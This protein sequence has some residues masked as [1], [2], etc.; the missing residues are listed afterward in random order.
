MSIESDRIVNHLREHATHP[1]RTAELGRALEVK[2]AERR[3]FRRVLRQ[4]VSEG[5]IS[6][7]RGGRYA[8]PERL[9][10]VT[11]V[12]RTWRSGH[13]V[14]TAADGEELFVPAGRLGSAMNGDRVTARVEGQGRGGRVEGRVVEILERS[15]TTIVGRYQPARGRNARVAYVVPMDTRLAHDVAVAATDVEPGHIVVAR[16]TDW[17]DEH[18]PPVG[19]VE[20]V[21]GAPDA[22]GVDVLAIIH[23]HELPLRHPDDVVDQ[24]ERMRERGIRAADLRDRTDLRELHAVTIDPGDARDHDD[25]LSIE[26]AD[27]GWRVGVHIA[28]VS[29]YVRAGGRID[30]EAQQRGTSVYL[31]D[32]ALP[33]LPEPLS[34][35]LC[36]LLP[37]ADRLTLSLLLDV[38]NSGDVRDARLVAAVIRSRHR[39][40]YES[41]QAVFD[42]NAS[43]D[44]LTDAALFAL[45]DVSRVLRERR[46]A[47][48]SLDFDLPEARVF[49][50]DAG[51]PVDV[52]RAERWESHRLVEDLM[53]LANETVGGRATRDGYPFIYRIHEPPDPLR[54]TQLANLARALG[55]QP[56]FSG[57]PTPAELQA[58][59]LQKAGTPVAQL[60][61]SL[62][63]R[64]MKQARYSATD[65]GHYGL[66]TRNYTHFTSPIRRYPD[67]IVHRILAA[68][69]LGR[70]DADRYDGDRLGGLAAHASGRERVAATAERDS[71]DLKRVQFMV[72]HIGSIF[73]GTISDVRAFG[74]IVL[75]DE[76]FVDGL[77]HV[78]SLGDD[79]YAF[80]EERFLLM[81]ENTGRRFQVG[82]RVKVQ[83]ASV[84]AGERR[85]EFVLAESRNRPRRGR[86]PKGRRR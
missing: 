48:G 86:V 14:V 47:R 49:L 23:S 55:F 36:S 44:P 63:L 13:G 19:E 39:L 40:T 42:G 6:R 70:S 52:R 18:R 24:A 26:T 78:S 38:A 68:R 64:S 72:R 30:A 4:L 75:L 50:D 22:P 65:R 58:L 83:V 17:G 5:R 33:M 53:L 67:L 32:R 61:A 46:L 7:L 27:G 28:D 34:S 11:G 76:Y 1:L 15:R 9:H 74:F 45:R 16:I 2:P 25:A 35:D 8:A 37:D 20:Q 51:M 69:H 31:V 57:R 80:V 21:L 60:L 81:G 84:D 12:L 66:A 77:V 79:Y 54:M 62:A 71:I 29:F 85:I 43:I 41:V 73:E 59:L 3:A 56:P 82:Q 10:L